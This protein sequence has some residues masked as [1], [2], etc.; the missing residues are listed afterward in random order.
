MS[1]PPGCEDLREQN[2][3]KIS[4]EQNQEEKKT[5]IDSSINLS[6]ITRI[7]NPNLCSIAQGCKKLSRCCLFKIHDTAKICVRVGTKKAKQFIF[8]KVVPRQKKNRK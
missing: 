4:A 8:R 1:L 3:L 7:K 2:R 5:K 6:A